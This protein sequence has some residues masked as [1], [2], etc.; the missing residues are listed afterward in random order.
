MGLIKWF[1]EKETRK[2]K[3]RFEKRIKIYKE[4]LERTSDIGTAQYYAAMIYGA[5]ELG[6]DLGVIDCCECSN[7]MHEYLHIFE[8][9][10]DVI[11]HLQKDTEVKKNLNIPIED[12]DFSIRAYHC[13]K[14]AGINILGDIKSIEQLRKVR[15]LGREC[16]QEV[17]DKL[18]ECGIEIPE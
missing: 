4:E 2:P 13:L 17:V 10:F 6:Y 16:C 8:K 3:N 15:N 11:T 1:K 12:C 9:Q 7:L 5:I 14:W 18:H